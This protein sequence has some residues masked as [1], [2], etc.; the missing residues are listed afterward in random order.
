M[1][2]KVCV[3]VQLLIFVPRP[4]GLIFGQDPWDFAIC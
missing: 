4:S 1:V 2:N 3:C